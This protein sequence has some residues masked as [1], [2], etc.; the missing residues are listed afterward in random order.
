MYVHKN[1]FLF[2]LPIAV[3]GKTLPEYKRITVYGG[4]GFEL[5]E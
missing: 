5:F 3:I 1:S 4:G 2:C